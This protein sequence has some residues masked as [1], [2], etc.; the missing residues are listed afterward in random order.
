MAQRADRHPDLRAQRAA[1]IR[2]PPPPHPHPIRTLLQKTGW[3]G[4]GPRPVPSRQWDALRSRVPHRHDW[5]PRCCVW[6]PCRLCGRGCWCARIGCAEGRE[7][8]GSARTV[9]ERD[10]DGGPCQGGP[11]GERKGRQGAR[12]RCARAMRT[13]C[14][15]SPSQDWSQRVRA[16]V[17]DAHG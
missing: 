13:R 11:W 17:Y 2:R 9:R 1:R 6:V 3:V 7:A 4:L 16:C 10:R 12:N 15:R 8:V 14:R 5:P